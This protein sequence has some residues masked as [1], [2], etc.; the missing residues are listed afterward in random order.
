VCAARNG[1]VTSAFLSF[2]GILSQKTG[3]RR[4][5][6]FLVLLVRFCRGERDVDAA[7]NINQIN[8]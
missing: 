1:N 6:F 2:N 4:F 8:I 5:L 3:K 7:A